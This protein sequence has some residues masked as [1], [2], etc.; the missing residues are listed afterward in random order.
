MNE[1]YLEY[2]LV[3]SCHLLSLDILAFTHINS[4]TNLLTLCI[5]FFA[6][7]LS[8]PT[9][10]Y[11]ELAKVTIRIDLL[12]RRYGTHLRLYK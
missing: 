12:Q 10:Y 9:H 2:I 3:H 5:S 4:S 7:A 6:L 11:I 1:K 8:V